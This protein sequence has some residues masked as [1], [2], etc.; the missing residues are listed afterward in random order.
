[1]PVPTADRPFLLVLLSSW[2]VMR[3]GV[4]NRL[5]F[6]R[7][8][9]LLVAPQLAPVLASIAFCPISVRCAVFE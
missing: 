5:Y 7:I 8:S 4:L 1:M 2:V 3:R 6:Q 9:R